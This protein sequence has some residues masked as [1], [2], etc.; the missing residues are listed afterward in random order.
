MRKSKTKTESVESAAK[1]KHIPITKI[2]LAVIG[3]AGILAVT[4]VVPN[5]FGALRMFGFGRGKYNEKYITN[6]LYR[7]R[8]D[9]LITFEEGGGKKL[10]RLTNKGKE[11]LL[12]DGDM[13]QKEKK[14][15]KKWDRKWRIVIFDIPERNRYIRE[16]IRKDL[17]NYGFMRLQDSVWIYPHDCE[18]F[19]VLLKADARIGKNLLYIVAS[20]VEYD[21]NVKRMFPKMRT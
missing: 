4:A 11:R 10:V 9:G 1:R 16:K 13:F 19:I 8:V 17:I 14:M 7:M 3:V 18:E 12:A 15:R 21:K 6:T 20:A 2:L 5:A